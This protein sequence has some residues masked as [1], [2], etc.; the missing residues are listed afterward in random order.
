MNKYEEAYQNGYG[1]VVNTLTKIAEGPLSAE[2][3]TRALSGYTGEG[4]QGTI[5]SINR[6]LEGWNNRLANLAEGEETNRAIQTGLNRWNSGFAGEGSQET[7]DFINKGL[8]KWNA[9]AD[10]KAALKSELMPKLLAG[11]AAGGTGLAALG[12]LLGRKTA[13]KPAPARGVAAALRALLGR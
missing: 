6:G 7:A 1:A 9:T 8:A 5:D 11:G 10:A 2:E 4:G 13:P 3:L 12:A